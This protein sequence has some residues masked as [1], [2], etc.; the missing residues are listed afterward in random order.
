MLDAA[1]VVGTEA[2]VTPFG[3][4]SCAVQGAIS[5]ESKPYQKDRKGFLMG[6]GAGALVLV[7]KTLAKKLGLPILA[8][9]AGFGASTDGNADI[10]ISALDPTG[11]AEAVELALK[12]ACIRPSELG[13][14]NTHGTG[15]REGDKGELAG[16]VPVGRRFGKRDSTLFYQVFYRPS[17]GSGR[18]A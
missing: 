12:M 2:V 5:N 7:E 18:R 3:L 9:V 10:S 8:Q 16:H 14:L 15:T 17:P 1:L 11:A 13:Y 4:E 6:E